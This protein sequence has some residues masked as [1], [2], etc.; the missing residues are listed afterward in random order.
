MIPLTGQKGGKI[1]AGKR[2]NGEET[3]GKKMIHG[4]TYAFYRDTSGKYYYGKTEKEAKVTFTQRKP[5]L[6]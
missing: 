4:T 1:M 5:A 3:W 2:K 6:Q